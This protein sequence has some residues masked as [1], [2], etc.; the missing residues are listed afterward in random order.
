M[1]QLAMRMLLDL[2]SKPEQVQNV[3]LQGELIVRASCSINQQ[4]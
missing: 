3:T 1:G 4:A 2:L